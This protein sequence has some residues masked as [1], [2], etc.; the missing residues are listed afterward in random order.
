MSSFEWKTKD[1]LDVRHHAI[2]GANKFPLGIIEIH[3]NLVA[4]GFSEW[5][6]FVSF[7][8]SPHFV[9]K[10]IWKEWKFCNEVYFARKL[11][12]MT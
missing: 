6:W 2:F 8:L 11:N 3:L 4:I 5:K 1:S 7:Y 12:L 10:D 9:S